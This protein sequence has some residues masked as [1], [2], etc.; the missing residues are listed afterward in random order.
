MRGELR[1]SKV[2]LLAAIG[3]VG[4]L[5]LA[6]ADR[7]QGAPATA[8]GPVAVP[9]PV[10]QPTAV[11]KGKRGCRPNCKGKTCGTDGCG[12]SCGTCSKAKVCFGD[13]CV[14]RGGE[15]CRT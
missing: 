7:L 5:A 2:A 10:T 1:L 14:K 9:Q 15:G 12:G 6:P 8:P 4:L 3:A 11:E 13:R